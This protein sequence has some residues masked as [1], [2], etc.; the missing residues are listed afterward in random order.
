METNNWKPGDKALCVKVGGPHADSDYP[1]L[2]LNYEYVVNK[3]SVCECGRVSLDVGLSLTDKAI[4]LGYGVKCDCGA[5]HS[6]KTGIHWCASFRFVKKDDRTIEE[7]IEEAVEHED[8]ELAQ[9][10]REQ[11]NTQ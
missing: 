10:L 8:Y 4:E 11:T 7:Q 3:V 9:Q 2:R 6:P 1:P 5:M